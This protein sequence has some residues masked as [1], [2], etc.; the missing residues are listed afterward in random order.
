MTTNI[1]TAG[2]THSLGLGYLHIVGAAYG[3]VDCTAQVRTRYAQYISG[4]GHRSYWSFQVT[5]D[6]FAWTPDPTIGDTKK[7]QVLIVYRTITDPT[8]TTWSDMRYQI[9]GESYSCLIE[10]DGSAVGTICPAAPSIIPANARYVVAAAWHNV[11]VLA[12]LKNQFAQAGIL[13]SSAVTPITI[14]ISSTSLGV[15]DPASGVYKQFAI[16]YGRYIQGQWIYAIVASRGL[17]GNYQLTLLPALL[18]TAE[19]RINIYSATWGSQDFTDFVRMR[20]AYD[21][22]NTMLNTDISIY[23]NN[24]WQFTPSLANFGNS[25]PNVNV[26]K[27]CV[28]VFKY[29]GVA[30]SG[31]GTVYNPAAPS[32]TTIIGN[33]EIYSDITDFQTIAIHED[34]PFSLTLAPSTTPPTMTWPTSYLGQPHVFSAVYGD[35]DCTTKTAQLVDAMA[36]QNSKGVYV[37]PLLTVSPASLNNGTDPI[38][39]VPKQISILLGYR[40]SPNTTIWDLRT[41][42]QVNSAPITT[43][44]IPR[45]LPGSTPYAVVQP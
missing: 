39:N 29:A 35:V 43:M 41:V 4:G 33:Y 16:I 7:K 45:T 31:L 21:M 6:F 14:S 20:Y 19:V 1:F 9:V 5:N 27:I 3:G 17:A 28:L 23:G 40:R 24:K 38:P 8:T 32:A 12:G 37:D 2:L 34:V 18:S 10:T 25:D 30:V 26:P 13:T 22:Y 44:S 15:P 11:D 42:V 36:T